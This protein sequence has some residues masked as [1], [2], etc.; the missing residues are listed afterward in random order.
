[1]H[2]RGVTH[3]KGKVLHVMHGTRTRGTKSL[4]R[5]GQHVFEDGEDTHVVRAQRHKVKSSEMRPQG[6]R[7]VITEVSDTH[8]KSIYSVNNL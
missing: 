1:V 4:G 2:W 3:K 7:L 6:R 8:L 5:H